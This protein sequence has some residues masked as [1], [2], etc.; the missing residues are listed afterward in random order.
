MFLKAT[1]LYALVTNAQSSLF[2]SACMYLLA[3]VFSLGLEP[4][5]FVLLIYKSLHNKRPILRQQSLLIHFESVY[6]FYWSLQEG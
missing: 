4:T 1:D 6:S 3:R 2:N 5:T